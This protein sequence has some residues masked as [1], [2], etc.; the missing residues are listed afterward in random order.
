M[1][2]RFRFSATARSRQLEQKSFHTTALIVG[3]STAMVSAG[4][5][6]REWPLVA[7]RSASTNGCPLIHSR[8]HRFWKTE[9][10]S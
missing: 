4:F 8:M 7:M 9:I 5:A 10:P 6:P 3:S 2:M 1:E